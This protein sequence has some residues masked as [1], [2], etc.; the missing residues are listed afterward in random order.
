MVERLRNLMPIRPLSFTE[1]VRLAEL[2][3]A[4][5]L[6]MSGVTDGPVPETVITDLPNVL[7]AV[8]P[9]KEPAFSKWKKGRWVIALNASESPTRQRF[10]LAHEFKHVL[11]SPYVAALYPNAY[12]VS[13]RDRAE[14]VCDHFAACL[15]MPRMWVKRVWSSGVQD[16]GQLAR[17]FDVSTQAMRMRLQLIGLIESQ[18]CRHAVAA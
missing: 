7:V 16:V 12:G 18:R 2:Q 11:D 4:R 1:G 14:Q 8:H 15:L 17:H 13:A 3:A 6:R 10:S 5:L 9:F